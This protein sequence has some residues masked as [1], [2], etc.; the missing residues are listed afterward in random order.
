MSL[1]IVSIKDV[2]GKNKSKIFKR[3]GLKAKMTDYA[4]LTGGEVFLTSGND[5]YG[6]YYL[7]DDIDIDNYISVVNGHGYITKENAKRRDICLRLKMPYSEVKHLALKERIN[8]QGIRE[9]EY[10]YLPSFCLDKRQ[11]NNL[12]KLY[13]KGKIAKT[14]EM[15]TDSLVR[16]Y[17]YNPSFQRNEHDLCQIG[18]DEYLR[19]QASSSADT[20]TLKNGDISFCGDVFYIKKEP[21][22]WYVD[23]EHDLMVSK[24]LVMASIQYNNSINQSDLDSM[25]IPD[26]KGFYPILEREMLQGVVYPR[27]KEYQQSVDELNKQL[28]KNIMIKNIMV[29]K[30]FEYLNDEKGIAR[31]RK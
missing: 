28:D 10:G 30:T 23:K 15:T 1:S 21:V 24:D 7:E 18:D 29:N 20:K 12:E 4:I 13:Q 19:L 2:K 3:C 11:G 27:K 26:I 6:S 31:T 5:S 17:H 16:F 8:S 25:I 22:V 14:G 9:V